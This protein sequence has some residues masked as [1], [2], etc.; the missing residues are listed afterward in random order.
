MRRTLFQE[1]LAVCTLGV[2][3]FVVSSC[4]QEVPQPS[5]SPISWEWAGIARAVSVAP[6]VDN[7]NYVFG[8]NADEVGSLSEL[9][10][11]YNPSMERLGEGYVAPDRDQLV[12]FDSRF[13]KQ[14]ERPIAD[15]GLPTQTTSAASANS[16]TAVFV[17][18]ESKNDSPYASRVV[19]ATEGTTSSVTRDMRPIALRAC[20]DK[21]AVWIERDEDNGS[22]LTLVRM[23][24]DGALSESRL[25]GPAGAV[26]SEFFSALGCGEEHSYISFPDDLGKADVFSVSGLSNQQTLKSEGKLEELPE[27]GV[28]RSSRYK[29]GSVSYFSGRGTLVE[30][31]LAHQVVRET[32]PL[33]GS[34]RRPVSA[35]VDGETVH[36][37]TQ[38]LDGAEELLV[39]SFS[40]EDPTADVDGARIAK[41]RQIMRDG[42]ANGAY[43]IPMSIF[44]FGKRT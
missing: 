23:G 18:N 35:T 13:H 16:E 22:G 26:A 36:I 30:V 40:F 1:F 43:T 17:F 10:S 27:P 24:A 31:D 29:E 6:S 21:T 32:E 42:T 11:V 19:L 38:P 20:T 3:A 12:V 34:D 4:A 9:A 25:D 2:C 41:L 14:S 8:A 7:H 28:N 33:I 39:H 15:L 44:P 5:K 37:V